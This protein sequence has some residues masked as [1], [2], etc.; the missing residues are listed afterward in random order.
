[1]RKNTQRP[2]WHPAHGLPKSIAQEQPEEPS[3]TPRGDLHGR[4]Q[5]LPLLPSLP[6]GVS[7]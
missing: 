3:H 4:W 7:K 1:M 5:S 2:G 6:L